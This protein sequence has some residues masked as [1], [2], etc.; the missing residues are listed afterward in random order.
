MEDF[1]EILIK[2]NW[3]NKQELEELFKD[4]SI[5]NCIN[6]CTS[7]NKKEKIFSAFYTKH[8]SKFERDQAAKRQSAPNFTD[9]MK[10]T[11]ADLFFKGNI[12]IKNRSE[13]VI[14]NT[15]QCGT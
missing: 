8:H 1:K 2:N 12:P 6:E 11:K 9:K 7:P 4:G 5:L 10:I 14:Y 13:F 3:F 15:L